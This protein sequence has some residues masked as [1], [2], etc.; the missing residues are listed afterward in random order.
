[1]YSMCTGAC[2]YKQE[3]MRAEGQKE[4]SSAFIQV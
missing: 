1:M 3:L 4:H 2:M